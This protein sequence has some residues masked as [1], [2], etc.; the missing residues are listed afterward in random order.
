MSLTTGHVVSSTRGLLL[1]ALRSRALRSRARPPTTAVAS[2]TTAAPQRA[3]VVASGSLPGSLTGSGCSFRASPSYPSSLAS[4]ASTARRRS[5]IIPQAATADAR[6]AE[7]TDV[8]MLGHAADRYGGVIVDPETLPDTVDAFADRLEASIAQWIA[9]GVRGVWLK[10]PKERAEF[11]GVAVH[12]GKFGFHHAEPGYVMMTRWLPNDEPDMLPPNASH[13]VG[14]GAF[15]TDGNGKVLLV[16]ERRG[17]AAAASRPDFWKL[18]TGLVEQGEDI[19]SAAVREVEEETGVRTEFHS[20]LGIRH[21]H[22]VAFGKSDMF[23][24][25]SLKLKTA[26]T[27]AP[28]RCASRSWRTRSGGASRTWRN[29][30]RTSCPGRTWT[31]C[32]ACAW[33]TRRGGTRAWGGRRCPSVSTGTEQSSRTPTRRRRRSWGRRRVRSVSWRRA[34]IY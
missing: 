22:N 7:E 11:V 13:Q 15:V 27:R 25:V 28:S 33:S 18:P 8:E 23:F 31:T 19:P 3:A 14:V 34:L 17:P 12:S 26:T 32:T 9:A 1:R 2:L 30:T 4:I 6:V 20:I 16:Q 24:L 29:T 21:G 5:T 10:I